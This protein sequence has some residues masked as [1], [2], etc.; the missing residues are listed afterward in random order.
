[1][2]GFHGLNICL[3]IIQLIISQLTQTKPAHLVRFCGGTNP[4]KVKI[5]DLTWVLHLRLIILSVISG[6]PIDSETPVVTL[7]LKIMF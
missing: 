4:P 2:F 7:N 5:L 1:M 3:E 6:I